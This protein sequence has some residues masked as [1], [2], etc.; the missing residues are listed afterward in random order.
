M[1]TLEVKFYSA[2]LCEGLGHA[3]DTKDPRSWSWSRVF[4]KKVLT[5]TLS[6]T[7]WTPSTQYVAAGYSSVTVRCSALRGLCYTVSHLI[8]LFS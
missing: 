7:L 2:V 1:N 4:F 5:T 6:K 3:L 8:C